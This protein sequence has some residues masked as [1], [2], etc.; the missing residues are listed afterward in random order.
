MP[1][2]GM[3]EEDAYEGLSAWYEARDDKDFARKLLETTLETL[4]PGAKAGRFLQRLTE[5]STLINERMAAKSKPKDT[6]RTTGTPSGGT[7]QAR[8]KRAPSYRRTAKK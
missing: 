3:P 8:S 4:P 7:Q 5:D 1:R 6:P 2:G